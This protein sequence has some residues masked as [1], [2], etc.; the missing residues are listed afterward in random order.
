MTGGFAYF[1]FTITGSFIKHFHAKALYLENLIKSMFFE[2]DLY[3]DPPKNV[4]HQQPV[5][6]TNISR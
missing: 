3:K 5:I 2:S 4:I 1:I 6:A